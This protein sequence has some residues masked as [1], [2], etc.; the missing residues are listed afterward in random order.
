M[1]NVPGALPMTQSPFP[2]AN[3]G[4]TGYVP[5]VSPFGGRG[6]QASGAASVSRPFSGSP[7]AVSR[8]QNN[9]VRPLYPRDY[10]P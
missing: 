3:R 8:P 10:T 1:G 4:A 9:A 2:Q 7:G 5:P 6:G